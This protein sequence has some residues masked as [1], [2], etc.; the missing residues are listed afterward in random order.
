MVTDLGNVHL[1]TAKEQKAESF[2]YDN[3]G[4]FYNGECIVG[5]QP[6][7]SPE[8]DRYLLDED[9]NGLWVDEESY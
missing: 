4:Y 1:K 7:H 5:S 6:G 2:K 8:K 9:F 3:G